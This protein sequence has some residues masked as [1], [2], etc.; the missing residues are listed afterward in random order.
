MSGFCTNVAL[1]GTKFCP[2][3]FLSKLLLLLLLPPRVFL[4]GRKVCLLFP[5]QRY[6]STLTCMPR[7]PDELS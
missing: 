5:R 1:E 3:Q 7:Q 2:S 6:A 4:A